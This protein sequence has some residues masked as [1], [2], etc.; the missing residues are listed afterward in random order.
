VGVYPDGTG[1]A[2]NIAACNT[3]VPLT[4]QNSVGNSFDWH[5]VGTVVGIT[6]TR[7]D[8]TPSSDSGTLVYFDG[9]KL[10]G[11]VGFTQSELQ[12]FAKS[13]INIRDEAG[14]VIPVI[15]DIKPGGFPNSINP[16]GTGKTP[17]AV[18]SNNKF[19][20]V[21]R[22]DQTSLTFGH[23]GDETSLAF[24]NAEDV[25]ADGLLDLI[26]QFNT[27]STGFLSGDTVGVLKGKT[28]DGI[29]VFGKDSVNIVPK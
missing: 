18:L 27:Q 14:V 28:I 20:A 10:P 12:L 26:C 9:F 8:V 19:D 16:S 2:L 3:G 17:L 24:C 25:N 22:I 7:S 21:A 13:G 23:T 5:A 11:A 1:D 29:P 4:C 6:Q 15:I